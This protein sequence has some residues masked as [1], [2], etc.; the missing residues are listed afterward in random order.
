[1]KSIKD[2]LRRKNIFSRSKNKERPDEKTIIKVFREAAFAEI[3]NLSPEDFGDAFLKNKTLHIKT[4]H[5]AI[6]SEVWRKR[7]KIKNETNR[8]LGSDEVEEIKVK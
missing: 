7:E 6:A 4:S 5:P 1:M 8:I 3:M 2:I